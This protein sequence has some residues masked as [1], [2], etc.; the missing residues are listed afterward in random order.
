MNERFK[1]E[2]YVK[3]SEPDADRLTEPAV[4]FSNNHNTFLLRSWVYR[5]LGG[6]YGDFIHEFSVLSLHPNIP[7][8]VEPNV[9]A[10]ETLSRPLVTADLVFVRKRC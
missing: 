4:I 8:S 2:E 7:F 6:V 9:I 3:L 1:V 5:K 10:A